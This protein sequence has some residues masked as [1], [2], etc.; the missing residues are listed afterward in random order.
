L[1]FDSCSQQ[2]LTHLFAFSRGRNLV[3]RA[4]SASLSALFLA[5]MLDTW[6]GKKSGLEFALCGTRQFELHLALSFCGCS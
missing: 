3:A 4:A 5:A 6:F 2:L 1:R